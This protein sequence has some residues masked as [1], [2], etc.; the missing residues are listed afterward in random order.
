MITITCKGGRAFKKKPVPPKKGILLHGITIHGRP[1]L[2]LGILNPERVP[3][4]HMTLLMR[5]V[6]GHSDEGGTSFYLTSYSDRNK[7]FEEFMRIRNMVI[8]SAQEKGKAIWVCASDRRILAMFHD[9]I[10]CTPHPE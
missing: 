7:Q 6:E 4:Y 1:I 3:Y 10:C 2:P 8:D 9:F 5:Q